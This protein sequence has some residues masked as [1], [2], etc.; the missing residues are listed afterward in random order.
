MQ[1]SDKNLK[2][3][4]IAN[5][6]VSRFLDEGD[7]A[8]TVCGTNGYVAPEVLKGI[9][10]SKECDYWGVGIIAY[11]LLSGTPPFDEQFGAVML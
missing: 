5:F 2:S 6:G 3:I 9:G 7:L 10:Y 8:S 11:I 1:S 4:K